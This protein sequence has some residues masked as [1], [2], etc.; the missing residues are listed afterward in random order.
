MILNKVTY[1][2]STSYEHVSYFAVMEWVGKRSNRIYDGSS[3]AYNM[4]G[5]IHNLSYSY[6]E[7]Q[8]QAV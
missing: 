4:W 3:Q 2:Q 7:T 1:L 5:T 6:T 8:F